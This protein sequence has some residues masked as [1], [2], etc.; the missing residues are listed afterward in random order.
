MDYTDP[1]AFTDKLCLRYDENSFQTGDAP[2]YDLELRNDGVKGKHTDLFPNKP[3]YNNTT[4]MLKYGLSSL[5]M[6]SD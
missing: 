6:I 2:A 3:L 1:F 4:L 5:S